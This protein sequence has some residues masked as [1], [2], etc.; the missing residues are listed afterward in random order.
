MKR[1]LIVT[2]LLIAV[3]LLSG[4]W[5][6]AVAR[7]GG[8]AST[9][10]PDP[11]TGRESVPA[12]VMAARVA[13]FGPPEGMKV[14]SS[15]QPGTYLPITP[16]SIQALAAAIRVET[17]PGPAEGTK[18]AA[19]EGLRLAEVLISA[20]GLDD[21]SARELDQVSLYGAPVPLRGDLAY[22]HA[23]SPNLHW[24][25]LNTSAS[26]IQVLP[27]TTEALRKVPGYESKPL[28]FEGLDA[29]GSKWFL[30]LHFETQHF[31][32]A[33]DGSGP[34]CNLAEFRFIHDSDT[35]V[36]TAVDVMQSNVIEV[37]PRRKGPNPAGGQ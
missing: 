2:I 12:S 8:G 32:I 15:R 22:R 35:G 26:Y 6:G 30:V 13:Q 37:A 9:P 4:L 33:R 7:Q 14:T 18:A 36:T 28:V 29:G 17:P 1:A 5:R 25:A 16:G 20:L 10:G 21:F 31:G 23:T 27:F 19:D 3:V 11:R 34:A 24:E